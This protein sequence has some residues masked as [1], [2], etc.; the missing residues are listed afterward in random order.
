MSEHASA[1][2]ADRCVLPGTGYSR[3]VFAVLYISTAPVIVALLAAKDS[4]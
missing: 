2:A 1:D 3:M 4:A